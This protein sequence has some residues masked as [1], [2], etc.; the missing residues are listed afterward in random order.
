MYRIALSLF[1]VQAGFHAFTASMPLALARGGIP[2]PEIGFIVGLAALVQIP[3]AFAA[4]ALVDRFGGLRLMVVGGVAYIAACF[5]LLL[6]GV[7]PGGSNLPFAV[8]RLLQGIGIG[9]ALPAGLS[10]VPQLVPAVRRGVALAVA[11][12]S[13]NLTLVVLPPASLVVLDLAGLDGVAAVVLVLVG[14][15]LG[16]VLVR[17]PRP[18]GVVQMAREVVP[19]V[20]SLEGP[21]TVPL[22]PAR[23]RLGIAYRASWTAP[24]AIV[25][26]FVAHWGVV[27]AYLPQRAEAAGANIGLFFAADGV[28]VLLMR[29]PAGWLS[30]RLSGL[31]LVLAGIAITAVGVALL[32]LPPVTWLLV[33][34]GLLTGVGA[35][36][37]VT[38]LLL[39]LTRRSTDADR[40]SAFALFSAGFAAAIA[41]GSI[42][43][44]PL[45]AV[46]GFE[47]AIGVAMV[48]LALA[49]G[50]ALGDGG[51]RVGRRQVRG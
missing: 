26:L 33:V 11:G 45:V 3:A 25:L 39:E 49:A 41:L 9:T 51:L 17:P 28:S 10:V 21:A 40:G 36:L 44:A 2:D 5:V 29:V 12:A 48:G 24:L 42:G 13:H 1:L 15:G 19:A 34:A 6:P 20:R 27:T 14:L 31:P 37:I 47:V 22:D 7:E 4:G 32:L 8:A 23:R 38:P 30:D 16:V 35:A 50:V 43:A 18:V 46:A